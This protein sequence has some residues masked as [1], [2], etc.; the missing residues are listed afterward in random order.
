MRRCWSQ[1]VI[2]TPCFVQVTFTLTR[3]LL[4]PLTEVPSA[5]VGFEESGA[6]VTVTVTVEELRAW[7]TVTVKESGDRA[8]VIPEDPVAWATVEVEK[9]GAWTTVEVEE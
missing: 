3:L 5:T 7:A 8:T 1:N 6:W 4:W 9:Y 2:D